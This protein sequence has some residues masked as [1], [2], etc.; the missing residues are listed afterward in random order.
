VVFPEGMPRDSIS[1]I[2]SRRHWKKNPQ[3]EKKEALYL[4]K[5]GPSRPEKLRLWGSLKEGC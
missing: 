5:G 1:V 2:I 4:K 3:G